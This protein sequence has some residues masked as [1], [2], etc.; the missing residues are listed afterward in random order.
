MNLNNNGVVIIP[1]SEGFRHMP[2]S[3]TKKKRLA[4]A[5]L[6]TSFKDEESYNEAALKLLFGK[7]K[8]SKFGSFMFRIMYMLGLTNL[9]WNSQLKK[10]NA[11]DK[12]FD[13]PYHNNPTPI[14]TKAFI[15]NK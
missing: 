6:G 4:V 8:S 2:P 12:C 7:E 9:W 5:S 15:S 13:A 14:T 3:M 11:K 10:N 1:G